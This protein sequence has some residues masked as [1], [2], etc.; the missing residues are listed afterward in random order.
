MSRQIQDGLSGRPVTW[1]SGGLRM[2]KV[3]SRNGANPM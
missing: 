3:A 1:H 2:G